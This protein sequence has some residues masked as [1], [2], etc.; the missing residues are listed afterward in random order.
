MSMVYKARKG[1][2]FGNKQ[3]Q[4]YGER[5]AYLESINENAGNLPEILI[6]D[7]KSDQSPL[8]EYFEWD[9]KKAAVNYRKQQAAILL[10]CIEVEITN[11]VGEK[12]IT[13]AFHPVMVQVNEETIVETWKPIGIIYEDETLRKQVIRKALGELRYWQNRYRQYNELQPI[14]EAMQDLEMAV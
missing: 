6:E 3:A 8:H 12:E 5:V 7:G 10:C 13:R 2:P 9:D 11:N 14:F 1:A 4:I